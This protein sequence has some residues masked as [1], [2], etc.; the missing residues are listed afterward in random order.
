LPLPGIEPRSPGRPARSQ[1]LY[2]R[3][4][5]RKK[6]LCENCIR[7]GTNEKI[8]PYMSVMVV[9]QREAGEVVISIISCLAVIILEN[10]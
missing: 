9:L 5:F 1:T 10:T 2:G 7:H 3:R 6:K 4:K 8:H